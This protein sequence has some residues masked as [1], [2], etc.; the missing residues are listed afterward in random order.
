MDAEAGLH[1]CCSH[2]IKSA[3]H[4]KA[5]IVYDSIHA[6]KFYLAKYKKD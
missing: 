5:H 6:K 2:A 1:L 3:P 4:N